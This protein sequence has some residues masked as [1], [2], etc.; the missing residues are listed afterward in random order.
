MVAFVASFMTLEP[1]D[2][3]TS[4]SPPAGPFGAGDVLEVEVEGIGVL[5]NPV[6]ARAVDRRYAQALN[7]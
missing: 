6:V 4:A 2:L 1:G 5:R 3:V 7:L